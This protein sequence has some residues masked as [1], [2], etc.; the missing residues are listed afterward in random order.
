MLSASAS[1]YTATVFT[2]SFLAVCMMRQ[3]IS[4]RFAMRILEKQA[5]QVAAGSR[6]RLGVSRELSRE[7]SREFSSRP[8]A[9]SATVVASY[10]SIQRGSMV[11]EAHRTRF[12]LRCGPRELKLLQTPM[13]PDDLQ[14]RAKNSMRSPPAHELDEHGGQ[15]LRASPG[16]EQRQTA[17]AQ[18]C[19]KL[20]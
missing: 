2:P 3:A 19:S 12:K 18:N 17:G 4:P 11:D 7:V 6:R 9:D 16:A 13:R 20:A 14:E 15:L 10:L 1:L 8:A 5:G